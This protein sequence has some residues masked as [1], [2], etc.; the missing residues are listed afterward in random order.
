ML[1][2]LL[3]AWWW[4][5]WPWTRKRLSVYRDAACYSARAWK[6]AVH[7]TLFR[8]S[9]MITP[10][11]LHAVHLCSHICGSSS[12]WTACGHSVPSDSCIKF[13]QSASLDRQRAQRAQSRTKG[14]L[15]PLPRTS[16]RFENR[17]A[18]HVVVERSLDLTFD[19]SSIFRGA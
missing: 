11:L 19:L 17:S 7:D 5:P 14:S 8:L 6:L 2:M 1:W 10:E 12:L 3:K 13:S 15:F 16:F 4:S 18:V 9:P